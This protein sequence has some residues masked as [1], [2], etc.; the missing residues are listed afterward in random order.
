VCSSDLPCFALPCPA[1]LWFDSRQTLVDRPKLFFPF[2][3]SLVAPTKRRDPLRGAGGLI[4]QGNES[5]LTP[6]RPENFQQVL[7]VPGGTL[8]A[9]LDRPVIGDLADEVEG[10]VAH[11]GHV[12]GA[13]TNPQA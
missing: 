2:F 1:A 10:E 9:A 3:G 6:Q 8:A 7:W 5:R 12:L 11:H 13:M 4:T